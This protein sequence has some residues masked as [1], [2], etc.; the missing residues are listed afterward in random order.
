MNTE[1]KNGVKHFL[2]VI[3]DGKEYGYPVA[4]GQNL[5]EALVQTGHAISA[6]CGGRGVCGKCLVKAE[7]ECIIPN[8]DG[9][10]LACRTNI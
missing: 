1:A 7:G 5:L 4:D 9:T 8:A 3:V 10:C 2:T 6:P